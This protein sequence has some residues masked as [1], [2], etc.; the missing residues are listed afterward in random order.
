MTS[1]VCSKLV[2]GP[3]LLFACI[4]Y[5]AKMLYSAIKKLPFLFTQLS[6]IL[7]GMTWV[8]PDKE[9]RG[10]AATSTAD[11][12]I[13]GQAF[14]LDPGPCGTGQRAPLSP[15]CLAWF[16]AREI[17]VLLDCTMR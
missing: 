2:L 11:S 13:A 16:L 7:R 12:A 8:D 10:K 5:D 14:G 6:T 15:Q 1:G 3:L 9:P 4:D 17:R